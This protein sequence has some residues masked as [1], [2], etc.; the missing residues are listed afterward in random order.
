MVY[1]QYL[2]A[3]SAQHGAGVWDI[4]SGERLLHDAAFVPMRYHRG[5]HSS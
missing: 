3:I 1:H 5:Q 4:L 2:F